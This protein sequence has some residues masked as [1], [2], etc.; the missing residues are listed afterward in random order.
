MNNAY[1][2]ETVDFARVTLT[3]H[4]VPNSVLHKKEIIVSSSF[5]FE[6]LHISIMKCT[7]RKFWSLIEGH[8]S[9]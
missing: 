5:F 1:I 7:K 8:V 6:D 4:I 9:P 3:L 2:F